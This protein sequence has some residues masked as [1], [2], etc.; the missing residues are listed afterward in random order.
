VA[1]D[2]DVEKELDSIVPTG[3]FDEPGAEEL[4]D[5]EA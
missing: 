4:E 3:D 1:D 5:E 2:Q